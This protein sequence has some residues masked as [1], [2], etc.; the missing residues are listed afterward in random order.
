[1]SG[2]V[3][4][5]TSVF[6]NVGDTI[7]GW[8][9]G[10]ASDAANQ[11][12]AD[13][14]DAMSSTAGDA[15]Q[16]AAESAAGSA[17]SDYLSGAAS[18][19]SSGMSDAIDTAAGVAETAGSNLSSMYQA[20]D[21]AAG[22]SYN[23]GVATNDFAIS[24]DATQINLGS[25]AIGLKAPYTSAAVGI[26]DPNQTSWFGRMSNGFNNMFGGG[27]SA[28]GSSS[29]TNSLLMGEM[30]GRLGGAAISAYGA[31]KMNQPHAPANF[32]GRTPGGGGG[33]LGIHTVNGG[34]GLAAGGAEAP[35]SG[36]PSQLMP[37][38]QAEQLGGSGGLTRAS[39]P[40]MAGGPN[41]QQTV[42]N[43]AGV[44]A[45]IPQGS[46]NFMKGSSNG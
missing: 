44:G 41:I 12:L 43:Q 17:A 27:D 30:L 1:M 22:A 39:P 46:V 28:P 3:S 6:S 25:D 34:F 21:S 4:D 14:A 37:N 8:F 35:P 20:L 19:A 45:L 16:Q 26:N 36:V 33:G 29:S 40:P 13:T 23:M 9:G 2:I 10:G 24:P 32:S 31:Y 7:A 38:A 18:A 5:V 42:A 11:A 15:A